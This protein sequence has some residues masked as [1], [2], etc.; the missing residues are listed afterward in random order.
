MVVSISITTAEALLDEGRGALAADAAGA[1]HEDVGAAQALGV[2]VDPRRKVAE[3]SRARVE[4]LDV[5]V[6][7]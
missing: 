2:V 4:E 3:V 7:F 5:G 6:A 1:V